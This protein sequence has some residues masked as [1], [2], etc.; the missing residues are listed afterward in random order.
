MKV[1]TKRLLL[2]LATGFAIACTAAVVF[3]PASAFAADARAKTTVNVRE[4]PGGKVV[5][6]LYAGETVDVKGCRQGTC[7]ITHSGPDG[8]VPAQYLNRS[9]GGNVDPNFNLS[10]N[11]PNGGSFSIGTGGFQFGIGGGNNNNSRREVCFYED[12]NYQGRA[13]C[14]NS[15]E[16]RSQLTGFWNDK[17]S[18]IRN[19]AGFRVTVCEDWNFRGSCRTYTSNARSLPS[20]NDTISSIRVR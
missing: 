14:M 12:Y 4:T 8:Y 10:F 13:F 2:N 9:A 15:G 3:T 18:S 6:R 11:F 7:Y 19:P 1:R 16:R 5:D 17:I 20:F